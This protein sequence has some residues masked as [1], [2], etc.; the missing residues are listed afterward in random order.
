VPTQTT[1]LGAAKLTG[2]TRSGWSI[3][4]LDAVT[5]EERGRYVVNAADPMLATPVEPLTNYFAARVRRELR[6]G[7]TIV[8]ALL[9]GVNRSMD[10]P[11]LASLLRS[12]AYLAGIDLNHSWGERNWALDASFAATR[13]AGSEEA[14]ART[15]R[16]SARFYQRPDATHLTYDPARTSLTGHAAQIAVTKLGGGH[17]GG[18]LAYQEKS[19]GYETNDIGFTGTVGRRG[20]STDV[21]YYE[22]QPGRIFRSWTLGFLTG[23]DWNY[24]GNHTTNYI[25][26]IQNLR[27]RNFWSLNSNVFYNFRSY[28]DQLTR[29]GPLARLP[30]RGD[31]NFSLETDGR[32]VFTIGL[33]GNV[34]WNQAD[35]WGRQVGLSLAVQ[36]APNV[37]FSFGPNFSRFHNVSQFVS[38][39]NDAEAVATLG[40]RS[41]FATLDQRELALDTRLSW[42]FTPKLSLQLFVQPLISTG[43]Y[44]D[45]KEL[46][47]PGT[48]DFDVYGRDRGT[49]ARDA[50]SG[51]Y[52]VDPDGAGPA[53]EFNFAEQNFN[54]RSLRSNVVFRWEYRPGS[55]IFLVWQQSRQGSAEIGDFNFRRDFG[56]IFENPATNVLAI[57]ATYWMGL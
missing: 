40:R 42:T 21:H 57:K 36:P 56:A 35:G 50:A 11:A 44:S 14:I 17:W 4:L 46:R 53:A 29:G 51:G 45:Y 12:N 31:A 32:G 43:D 37:Q 54:F 15:Q 48:F 6:Q 20:I 30:E 3:A 8:G 34:N 7:N 9:T 26:S 16:A 18:N 52:T 41:V 23:N 22:P 47:A 49:I 13:L 1:I 24:D 25:G 38:G 39:L 55:T 5:P 33:N 27:F 28:D 10:D 19:P 2:K